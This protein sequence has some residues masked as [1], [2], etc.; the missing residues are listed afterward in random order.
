M[1]IFF[2]SKDN[3]FCKLYHLIKYQGNTIA[4][5]TT[6]PEHLKV[7]TILG[8]LLS[9]N[10]DIVPEMLTIHNGLHTKLKSVNYL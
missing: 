8:L 4:V 10:K 7:F 2:I 6:S 1:G 9:G 3:I 5:G